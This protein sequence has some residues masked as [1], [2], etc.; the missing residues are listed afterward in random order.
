MSLP[1]TIPL[2]NE[3]I[4]RYHTK[5]IGRFKMSLRRQQ[6]KR[7]KSNRFRLAKHQLST[8]T[9]LF[10]TFLCRQARLW[11]ELPNFTFH[12]QCEH[13]TTNF[14][15]YPQLSLTQIGF[16][17]ASQHARAS[18]RRRLSPC[19]CLEASL[20]LLAESGAQD[21]I[22]VTSPRSRAPS[23]KQNSEAHGGGQFLV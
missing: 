7:Q 1:L 19:R 6:R 15:F 22:P 17:C 10:C 18:M 8:C 12:R 11:R 14:S 21:L 2:G 3:E 16:V 4:K 20:P 9:K 23:L 5:V 13:T